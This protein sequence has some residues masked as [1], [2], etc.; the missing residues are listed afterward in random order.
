M[1]TVG[2][3]DTYPETS[4][5]RVVGSA[6]SLFGILMIALPVGIIG[7]DFVDFFEDVE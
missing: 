6:C 7:N 2:F 4:W 1:T 3:G 5:G